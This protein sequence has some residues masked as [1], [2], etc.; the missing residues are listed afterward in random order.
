[1][2]YKPNGLSTVYLWA[3]LI[4]FTLFGCQSRYTTVDG[5]AG[6]EVRSSDSYETHYCFPLQTDNLEL[7]SVDVKDGCYRSTGCERDDFL[8]KESID[9]LVDSGKRVRIRL[10]KKDM[11][12]QN[13]VVY[14]N[15]VTV[16]Q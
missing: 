9:A 5:I 10:L 3:G 16:L 4:L 6:K 15:D 8:S 1:M 14:A 2:A 11:D 7:K 13:Y 12:R